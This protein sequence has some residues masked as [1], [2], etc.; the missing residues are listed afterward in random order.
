M[1]DS[2]ES[3]GTSLLATM[4]ELA[5]MPE[6]QIVDQ[7][8]LLRTSVYV[9][10]RNHAELMRFLDFCEHD[11]TNQDLWHMT[12]IEKQKSVARESV[13]LLH[14]F[15]ASVASLVDHTRAMYQL[16][17]K[18]GSFPEY[19]RE[20]SKRFVRDPLIQFVQNL[21][22]YL[23]HVQS[24]FITYSTT[25]DFKTGQAIIR[26]GLDVGGL[27][28]W[29]GWNS[30]AKQYLDGA[31]KLVHIPTV[32]SQYEKRVRDFYVWF[33]ERED[34]IHA[35]A[36]D[37][38]FAK[39]SEYF[40]L[41]IE[42]ALDGYFAFP[43]SG[44]RVGDRGLFLGLFDLSEFEALQRLPAPSSERTETALRLLRG[45]LTI[46]RYIEDKIRR[47]YSEPRFFGPAAGESPSSPQT[48]T[49]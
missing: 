21:R 37:R 46:P 39:E 19:Q 12:T 22:N 17:H 7:L 41:E 26:L 5:D 28:A 14:N 20:V 48:T 30:A 24:P 18:D 44:Q 6:K 42:N 23:L 13:R 27:K 35:A 40:L 49:R 47:A 15:V 38:F 31:E 9:F 11:P 34:E 45:H 33:G 2:V 3:S 10:S 16:L 1:A 29:D 25:L 36:L 32:V 43:E 8:Q 4:H